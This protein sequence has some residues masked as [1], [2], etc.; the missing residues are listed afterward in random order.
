M[1]WSSMDTTL[2]CFASV[3]ITTVDLFQ[4]S[5]RAGRP[6]LVRKGFGFL[7]VVCIIEER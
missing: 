7:L 5:N 1:F 4:P 2:P 6:V 3:P